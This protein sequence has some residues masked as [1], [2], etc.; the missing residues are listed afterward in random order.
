MIELA[1]DA[2]PELLSPRG[3]VTPAEVAPAGHPTRAGHDAAC[4]LV[5]R[6]I[7]EALA[8]RP[9]AA[10]ALLDEAA[11][12]AMGASAAVR[13]VVALNRAQALLECGDLS[14]ADEEATKALR[15]ARHERSERWAGLASIGLA[16]VH[17]ARGRRNDARTRLAEAVRQLA[18]EGDPLRRLQCHYL[19]G[20]IAWLA[21]DP[22][23]AGAHYRDALGLARAAR[24]QA[25]I[26]LLTLRFEHR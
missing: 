16:L 14:G 7:G 1:T 23:R 4:A 12:A 6:A 2:L 8:S 5:D 21:E 15:L 19:L 26:E 11:A 17:L 22:I 25:W 3:Y 9:A 18:R 10:L 20:E 24:E 13:L